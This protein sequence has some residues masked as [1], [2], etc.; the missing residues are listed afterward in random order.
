MLGG[1]LFCKRLGAGQT[2]ARGG[3]LPVAA[4][5]IAVD[6]R[7]PALIDVAR[8]ITGATTFDA[9]EA[10]V[11]ESVVSLLRTDRGR[12]ISWADLGSHGFG[13]FLDRAVAEERPVVA[14]PGDE[15]DH[16][17]RLGFCAGLAA[18]IPV[19][20]GPTWC[21]LVTQGQPDKAFGEEELQLVGFIT[22]L[23]GAAL[24]H[25][26]KSEAR[27]RSLAQ[28]SSDVITLVDTDGLVTYQSAAAARV[29]D[30]SESVVGRAVRDWAH[31]DDLPAFEQALAD[32]QN[33]QHVRI[34]C[35]LMH[36]KGTYIHVET[37]ISNLLDEPTVAALVLN[38]R[39]VSERR[40]LEDELRERA[41]HDALTGLP[42]RT[43]FH[44]RA[45]HALERGLRERVP[46]C[47]AFMDLDDFKAVNDTFGHAV[48]DELLCAIA[49]R[50]ASCMRPT[51]TVTRL[52]GDEFA[53]LLEDTE[54]ETAVAIVERILAAVSQPVA[55][56]GTEMVIRASVGLT[57][58]EGLY[59]DADQLLAH[60]DAAMYAA[61]AK[62]T[63]GFEL[64]APE[65][66]AATEARLALRREIDRALR[67]DEFRLHYQ[68]IIDTCTQQTVG[69][70][71]LIRWEHPK[72]GLLTPGQFID[73]AENS[74]QIVEMGQWVLLTACADAA[75]LPPQTYI[76]VNLSARQLQDPRLV[77]HVT[78]ALERSGI[79]ADRLILEITETAA[80]ADTEGTISKLHELKAVGVKLALDDFGTGYSPLSYLRRFPV[81]LIKIDRSFVFEIERSSADLAIVRGVID[82]AHALGLRAV[83][84]GVET[85]AQYAVLTELGCDLGQGYLWMRPAPLDEVVAVV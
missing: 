12:L 68:P 80:M 82:M 44:D 7:L 57:C 52:G 77:E 24:E 76:S 63:H 41:L 20:G 30:N 14:E 15:Q 11:C 13:S 34:E 27:F 38:T 83:A 70:E 73:V 66:Q 54:L 23:G 33:R 9:V 61:K 84:E 19:H 16:L 42:N 31:P 53:F 65:M 78:D 10:A 5:G 71:A 50:L 3:R 18:P 56:A 39:D 17:R 79:G 8:A 74:G 36:A 58:T 75:R 55:L 67:S 1:R 60:A 59:T 25:L 21:L 85:E 46:I 35:R 72:R 81:D 45:R 47:V 49:D 2:G 29:F 62:G 51:D 22:A 37:T 32:A 48:G 64:F 43:L 6:D 26:A 69:M 40:R 28:N 4:G